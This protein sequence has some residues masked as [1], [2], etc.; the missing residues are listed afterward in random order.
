MRAMHFLRC[1]LVASF[2]LP[3]LLRAELTYRT[4]TDFDTPSATAMGSV[5]YG[6]DAALAGDGRGDFYGVASRYGA[7]GKGFIFRV[8]AGGQKTTLHD[9]TGTDGEQPL[10]ALCFGKD[11]AF[12]GTTS[13]GG[14]NGQG[15]IFKITDDGTFTVLHSFSGNEGTTARGRLLLARDGHFYGTTAEGGESGQGTLYRY[16]KAGVLT[17]LHHFNSTTGHQPYAGVTQ[18]A[19]G[20]LYGT[21]RR[22]GM[23]GY[24]V[25]YRISTAGKYNVLH[26]FG[27]PPTAPVEQ[28][29]KFDGALPRGELSY[30]GGGVFYGT[31]SNQITYIVFHGQA[32]SSFLPSVGDSIGNGT[33]FHISTAG[34]YGA[35]HDTATLK[36]PL[37]GI[38]RGADG[39]F[40]GSTL[41]GGA[42]AIGTLFRYVPGAK[43][44][45]ITTF[46]GTN[47]AYPQCSLYR[48]DAGNLWG[49]VN[50]TN[51]VGNPDPIKIGSVFV[52]SAGRAGAKG[53]Y[54]AR[55]S[56]A[57]ETHAGSGLVQLTLGATGSFTGHVT[58]SGTAYGFAGKFDALG[59]CTR[60][61]GRGIFPP[62]LVLALHLDV[63]APVV[64]HITG[65][66]TTGALVLAVD[67][68]RSPGFPLGPP[69]EAGSYTASLAPP[70]AAGVPAG[71]GHG[72]F[73]IA[74]NGVI[75]IAGTL[76]DLTPFSASSRLQSDATFPLY[77]SL[78]AQ[79]ARG[80][81]RGDATLADLTATDA[82]ATLRWHKPPQTT[83]IAAAGLTTTL[84][85]A[86]S[87]YTPPP[88]FTRLL[89]VGDM[90]PNLRLE[91]VHPILTESHAFSLLLN[92]TAQFPTDAAKPVLVF[93]KSTGQFSGSLLQSGKRRT[94][95]GVALQKTKLGEGLLGDGQSTQPVHLAP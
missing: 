56:D 26:H 59:D 30:A 42:S 14:A 40:Y 45:V 12:Y 67:L 79:K 16:T 3:S 85:L 1:L 57:G 78:Y 9:F 75:T 91:I 50:S 37:G 38:A 10:T 77:S 27:V 7:N 84:P 82:T 76:P 71:T 55:V 36:G 25:I 41:S 58:F 17:V 94:F 83:G 6:L 19:D 46:T 89:D 18:G 80:S 92:N 23:Y 61:V 86:A 93:K 88:P 22:G 28:V 15:N 63:D 5:Y 62:P 48:D 72:I 29:A 47:G 20:L 87:R 13:T 66:L 68:P 73:S 11:G 32:I 44:T 49:L 90:L 33:I 24:G 53:N 52:L 31:T 51:P 65:T 60:T 70:T 64:S 43:P 81:L 74:K 35:T 39:A 34:A 95:T 69:D 2:F 54:L 21:G 8:T 4:V